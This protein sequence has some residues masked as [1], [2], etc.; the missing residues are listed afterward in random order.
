VHL[1]W[2]AFLSVP[3]PDNEAA[4][5]TT[6]LATNKSQACV[7]FDDAV[8]EYCDKKTDGIFWKQNKTSLGKYLVNL[9][10]WVLEKQIDHS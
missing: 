9:R 6:R 5:D 7:S 10:R 4:C 2:V 3:N 8:L 1:P